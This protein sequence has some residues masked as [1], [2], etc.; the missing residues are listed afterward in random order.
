MENAS[1]YVPT[2]K[3]VYNAEGFLGFYRGWVPPFLGSII[4]R[5]A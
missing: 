5:S 3:K 2:I 1:K 4:F